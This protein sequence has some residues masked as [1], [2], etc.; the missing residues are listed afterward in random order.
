MAARRCAH[1]PCTCEMNE[2]EMLERR[3]RWYCSDH[4][5]TAVGNAGECRCGHPGCGSLQGGPG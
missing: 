3:G 2:T 5:A 4:C 1:E